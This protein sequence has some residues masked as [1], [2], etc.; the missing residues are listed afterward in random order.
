MIDEGYR[1]DLIQ[2]VDKK[3]VQEFDMFLDRAAL[4][5]NSLS[6]LAEKNIPIKRLPELQIVL[7][8]KVSRR[9]MF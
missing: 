7:V 8:G 4:K 1:E 6:S 9:S 3:R 2:K 5:K